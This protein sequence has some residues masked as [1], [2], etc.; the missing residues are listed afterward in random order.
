MRRILGL[1]VLIVLFFHC[2]GQN[3]NTDTFE[4][5]RF[6][7]ARDGKIYEIIKTDS[8]WW[9]NE[10]LNFET[11]D[12]DC[13]KND[14]ANCDLYGRLYSYTESN[15]ICPDRW[16]LPLDHEIFTLG[17]QLFGLAE[18]NSWVLKL[19]WE[20]LVTKNHQG[21]NWIA[22]GMKNKRRYKKLD[23]ISYWLLSAPGAASHVHSYQLGKSD[24]PALLFFVHSHED[25]NPIAKKRKFGVRCVKPI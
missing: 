20:D 24:P 23:S 15:L 6:I 1:I 5:D 12:S 22:T 8:L 7:D 19:T 18:Y 21:F 11:E 9:F 16:R 3:S 10:N 25:H 4:T 13:F 17:K 14:T 2:F